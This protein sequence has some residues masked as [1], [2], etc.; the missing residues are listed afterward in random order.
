M[1][2]VNTP[3]PRVRARDVPGA[4]DV[5][6]MIDRIEAARPPVCARAQPAA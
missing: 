4:Y 1:G 5:L 3:W 2:E 6:A